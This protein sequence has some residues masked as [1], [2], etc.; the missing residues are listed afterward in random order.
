MKSIIFI[1]L[2]SIVLGSA[3]STTCGITKNNHAFLSTF[4]S[5]FFSGA[6]TTWNSPDNGI[7]AGATNLC[8][9][10]TP[11]SQWVGIELNKVKTAITNFGEKA[12]EIGNNW[13]KINNLITAATINGVD[14]PT[15]ALTAASANDRS[16]AS[17][18]E[19]AAFSSYPLETFKA[20]FEAFKTQAPDCYAEYQKFIT[21][22][23]CD[24]CKDDSALTGIPDRYQFALS[25]SDTFVLTSNSIRAWA[26]ACTKVW[27]F[28]WKAGWFV[29]T[30]AY[31]NSKKNPS[32]TYSPPAAAD[33]F[34]ITTGVSISAVNSGFAKCYPSTANPLCDDS[35]L[36]DLMGAFVEVLVGSSRAIGRSDTSIMAG[37]PSFASNGRR[38]ILG[39]TNG[40]IKMDDAKGFDY[41]AVPSNTFFSPFPAVAALSA[42]D[43]ATWSHGYVAPVT[44]PPP[45][46]QPP[47]PQPSTGG[48]P[49]GGQNAGQ[50]TP[51]YPTP[52]KVIV[53]S[54]SSLFAIMPIAAFLIASL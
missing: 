50:E 53:V 2:L 42:A 44:P 37:T 41:T 51:K 13:Q 16:G 15:A 49:G 14:T 17:G 38:R 10:Q 35:A 54:A 33:V 46:P 8:C 27:N 29:Q 19:F 22:L 1:V 32:Y 4:N 34:V 25:L 26:G 43:T 40:N 31:L 5:L 24:A 36:A 52:N 45:S 6:G 20:D 30:V 12:L 39:P 21:R 11:M 23:P 9:L 28:M 47:S 48:Q 18:A 7:C 3:R